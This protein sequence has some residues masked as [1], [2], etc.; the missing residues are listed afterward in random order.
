M[1]VSLQGGKF[2]KNAQYCVPCYHAV[3]FLIPALCSV[4]YY[5]VV[6]RL[7]E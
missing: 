7:R 6:L 4:V 5:V 3:I 2:D 1:P